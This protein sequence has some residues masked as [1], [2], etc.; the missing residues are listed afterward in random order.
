MAG[1]SLNRDTR[2]LMT[3]PRPRIADLDDLPNP[4]LAGI[5]DD[6]VRDNPFVRWNATIETT[7]GCPYSCTFCDW[8]SMTYSKVKKY[9]NEPIKRAL[10]WCAK[11]KIE[12]IHVADANFGI[13]KEKDENI[14]DHVIELRERTGYPEVFC[15][16]W[17]KNSKP[18]VI[19][20]I[21]KLTVSGLDR[22]L[23]LS[24][25]SMSDKVLGAVKRRNMDMSNFKAMLELCNKEQ[26]PSYTELILG[27][28]E[29]TFDSWQ[30]GICD[31][32]E[33]GQH[34][35]IDVWLHQILTNAEMNSP[36]SHE[37]YKLKTVTTK[38]YLGGLESSEDVSETAQLVNATSTM[39]FDDYIRSYM[40]S[41]CVINFHTYGWTQIFARFL[42]SFSNVTYVEFY[43]TL[44]DYAS[45]GSSGF[46]HEN[47]METQNVIT[48]FLK[49]GSVDGEKIHS[50]IGKNILGDVQQRLHRN[51]DKVWKDLEPFF[52][53]WKGLE[54]PLRRD[55][56]AFQ[57]EFVTDPEKRYPYESEY[58]FNIYDYI[59]SS[60][61]LKEEEYRCQFTLLEDYSDLQ[62]Y[63]GKLY[64]RRN[65]GWGKAK[66][67]NLDTASEISR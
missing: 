6:L 57:K 20:M 13:F 35:S 47:F 42:R 51:R 48:N 40:F 63:I 16:T 36:E 55:V 18:N 66:V 39:L 7:R 24:V 61:P 43:D 3:A 29:E 1:I 15:A 62:D 28:P 17:P 65:I 50:A 26:V 64:F 58:R 22:G 2:S 60:K 46:L 23:T 37:K 49:T 14:V 32:I 31:I 59:T 27:L 4:Y 19:R 53:E 41:W 21:K 44:F 11:N 12:F 33:A 56:I 52:E 5:F 30:R 67:V 38:K 25:Q 8:G 9:D 54:L 34:N 45:V 10:D